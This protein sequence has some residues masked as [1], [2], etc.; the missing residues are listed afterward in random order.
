MGPAKRAG[1]KPSTA[2]SYEQMIDAYVV[3][4]LG[5]VALG[6]VDGAILNALYAHL[7]ADGRTGAR[8]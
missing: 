6:N 7:L 2:V 1:L 4:T 8:R 5:P 3:P